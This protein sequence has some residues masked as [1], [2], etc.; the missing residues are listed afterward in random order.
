MVRMRTI[1]QCVAELRTIDPN[2]AIT[3]SALRRWVREG[4]I[5]VVQVGSKQLV[6]L[7]AVELYISKQLEG[8]GAV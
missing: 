3:A 4:E 7:E 5:N 6:S 1:R 2:T 8:G